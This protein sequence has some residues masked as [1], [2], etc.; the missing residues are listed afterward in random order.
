MRP[1]VTFLDLVRSIDS[2][3]AAHVLD[4]WAP[5]SKRSPRRDRGRLRPCGTSKPSASGS[6]GR[7]LRGCGARLRTRR[8][9]RPTRSGALA[10]DRHRGTPARLHRPRALGRRIGVCRRDPGPGRGGAR[11]AQDRPDAA[12]A[13]LGSRV[14]RPGGTCRPMLPPR[15]RTQRRRCRPRDRGRGQP[16]PKDP[17]PAHPA[18]ERPGG[19]GPARGGRGAAREHPVDR[20]PRPRRHLPH[21]LGPA[22]SRG[23]AR[24]LSRIAPGRRIANPA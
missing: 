3:N 15:L 18:D 10:P 13:R 4:S 16:Q 5:C 14:P 11:P 20:R 19:G 9:D 23:G 2:G 21:R 7:P 1:T 22:G 12:A 6:R 17:E 24:A 8:R